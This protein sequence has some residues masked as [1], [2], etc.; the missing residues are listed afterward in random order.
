M[1]TAV[2][3]AETEALTGALKTDVA[4]IGGGFTGLNAALHLAE[5]GTSVAVL[6]AA[7]VGF[8]ASGRSGGQVNLGLNLGP[9]ALIDLYGPGP[10]ERLVEAI[11]KTP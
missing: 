5:R 6:E 7:D 8:G 9:K 4:I 11:V 1:A 3:P 10:G 2:A